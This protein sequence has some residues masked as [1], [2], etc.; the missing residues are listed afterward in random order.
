MT[1]LS[2]TATLDTTSALVAEFAGGSDA[3]D[4]RH[5]GW[6]WCSQRFRCSVLSST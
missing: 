5:D 1:V 3:S 4:C 6:H 2:T